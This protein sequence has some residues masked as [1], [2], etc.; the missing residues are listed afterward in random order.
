MV[1]IHTTKSTQLNQK[2]ITINARTH[3]YTHSHAHT[4]THTHTH[5]NTHR[6]DIHTHTCSPHSPTPHTHTLL[7]LSLSLSLSHTH[8]HTHTPG[9]RSQPFNK[10]HLLPSL[11]PQILFKLTA[12]NWGGNK[13]MRVTLDTTPTI[14]SGFVCACELKRGRAEN[15]DLMNGV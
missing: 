6:A 2:Q 11:P 9:G 12:R 13:T 1:L 5:T 10:C 14:G 8:T 7:S 15:A 3:A 4:H